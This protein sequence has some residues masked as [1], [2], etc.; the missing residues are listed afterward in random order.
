MSEIK[1]KK[2]KKKW[3]RFRHKVVWFIG[4]PIVFLITRLFY[5]YRY[6]KIK[7][8]DARQSLIIS[9]HQNGFDQFFVAL[10]FPQVIYFIASEALFSTGFMG[11]F[12]SWAAGPIPIKKSTTDVRAVANLLRIVKEGGTV[13]IFPE[14]NRSFDGKNGYI[15]KSVAQLAKKVKI[16]LVLYKLEGGY[17]THPRWSDTRR[18]GR[19]TGSIARVLEPE[20]LEEMSVDEIYDIIITTLFHDDHDT[21]GEFRSKKMAEHFERVMYVCPRCGLSNFFGKGNSFGCKKCGLTAEMQPDLSI[22]L[23]ENDASFDFKTEGQWYDYQQDYIRKLDKNAYTDTPAYEDKVKEY[24]VIPYE[25]TVCTM[26]EAL[27]RLYSDR[28]EFY[29]P[30]GNLQKT[31]NF[32]DMSAAAVQNANMLIIY[33]NG[34]DYYQIHGSVEFNAIKYVNF[35]YHFLGTGLFKLTGSDK[36]SGEKNVEFLGI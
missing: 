12:I 28:Y 29:L 25:N 9:N 7:R 35:Y 32:S 8:K 24:K 22:K 1:R 20:E 14:G 10:N 3:M 27:I 11:R 15:K 19:V 36:F 17:G 33:M 18:K 30:D 26:E 34:G 16:P 23:S 6:K 4:R 31:V 2:K 13:G 21:G 5:R